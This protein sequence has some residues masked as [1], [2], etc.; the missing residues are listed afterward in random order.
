MV[1]E[2]HKIA[3]PNLP[4]APNDYERRWVDQFSNVLRLFFS[5]VANSINTSEVQDSLQITDGI[6]APEAIVGI[7]QLYVDQATGSLMVIFGNGTVKALATNANLTAAV[8]AVAL[9]PAGSS[10]TLTPS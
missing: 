8:T 2:A 9:R 6:K 7:A 1:Q 4:V 3:P 5:Q 10:I